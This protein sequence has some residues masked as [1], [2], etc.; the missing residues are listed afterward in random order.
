MAGVLGDLSGS[1]KCYE[2]N[3]HSHN[4]GQNNFAKTSDCVFLSRKVHFLELPLPPVSMLILKHLS[5][6]VL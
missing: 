4:A 3:G 1:F 5:V 6:N 2:W